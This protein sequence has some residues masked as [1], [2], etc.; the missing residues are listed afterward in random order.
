MEDRDQLIKDIEKSLRVI[1]ES[2]V[3]EFVK[4]RRRTEIRGS[5]YYEI[6]DLKNLKLFLEYQYAPRELNR[7]FHSVLK[8]QLKNWWQLRKVNGDWS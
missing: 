4:I 2:N 5:D 8:K 1:F 6:E 7:S 3:Q